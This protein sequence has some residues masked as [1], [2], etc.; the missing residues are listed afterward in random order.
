VV[1]AGGGN[2]AHDTGKTQ[3]V[4]LLL[5]KCQVFIAPTRLLTAHPFAFAKTL[6]RTTHTLDGKHGTHGA[7]HVQHRAHLF[8]GPAAL[9]SAMHL[10]QDLLDHG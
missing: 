10:G 7:A 2:R 9:A 5:I 6:L 4:K 3:C 8:L 1:G